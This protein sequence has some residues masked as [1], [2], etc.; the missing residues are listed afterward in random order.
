M[1]A[2]PSTKFLITL[3]IQV[4]PYVSSNT[5][6]IS[7]H[8]EYKNHNHLIKLIALHM[9]LQIKHCR[10]KLQQLTD[11]VG[12]THHVKNSSTINI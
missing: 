9:H 12:T 1:G 6:H 7:S 3:T 8:Q 11:D 2:L 5:R 10:V 4:M